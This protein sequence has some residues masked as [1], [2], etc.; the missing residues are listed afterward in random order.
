MHSPRKSVREASVVKL[1][2]CG[3][4]AQCKVPM[5]Q[6]GHHAMFGACPLYPNADLDQ[7]LARVCSGWQ[8]FATIAGISAGFNGNKVK[9]LQALAPPF[10]ATGDNPIAERVLAKVRRKQTVEACVPFGSCAGEHPGNTLTRS[11]AFQDHATT[12]CGR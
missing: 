6:S 12:R 11:H 7:G 5:S 4:C 1:A 8:T 10:G 9:R 3:M 2:H